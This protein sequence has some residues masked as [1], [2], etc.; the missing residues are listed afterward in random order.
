MDAFSY[1]GVKRRFCLASVNHVVDNLKYHITFPSDWLG[2]WT[3][4]E[5]LIKKFVPWFHVFISRTELVHTNF[6]I[7]SVSKAVVQTKIECFALWFE[8]VYA[9]F[10]T[11]RILTFPLSNVCDNL[12]NYIQT[13]SNNIR[14]P[15]KLLRLPFM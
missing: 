11:E 2:F 6:K 14:N 5:E 1:G 8:F 15:D 12:K 7:R 9:N 13:M 4:W 3:C 10:N